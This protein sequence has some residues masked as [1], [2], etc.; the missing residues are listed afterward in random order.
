MWKRSLLSVRYWEI[1]IIGRLLCLLILPI[2]FSGRPSWVKLEYK[3]RK[4][5]IK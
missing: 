3:K 1:I 5:R 2:G 4:Q